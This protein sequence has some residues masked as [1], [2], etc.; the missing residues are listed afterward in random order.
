MLKTQNIAYDFSKS[1]L[2]PKISDHY[3]FHF[4]V[5]ENFKEQ[6]KKRLKIS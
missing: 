4:F 6:E 5:M 2:N 1:V 3:H